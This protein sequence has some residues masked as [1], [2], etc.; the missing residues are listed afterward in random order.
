MGFALEWI[1]LAI[2]S[3]RLAKPGEVCK[4]DFEGTSG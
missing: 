3:L 1:P 2:A 4:E